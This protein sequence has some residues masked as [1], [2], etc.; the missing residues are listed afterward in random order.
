[1]SVAGWG[2][3]DSSPRLVMTLLVKNEADII[4][5]NIDFHIRRGSYGLKLVTA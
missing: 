1:M 5:V 3:R 2:P 4:G